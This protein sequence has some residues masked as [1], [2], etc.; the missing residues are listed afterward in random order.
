M[1]DVARKGEFFMMIGRMVWSIC[2]VPVG[3]SLATTDSPVTIFN[4]ALP[5][6]AMSGPGLEG[7]VLLFPLSPH[8]LLEL[9]HPE[10]FMGRPANF[11]RELPKEGYA[12]IR[13]CVIEGDALSPGELSVVNLLLARHADRFVVANNEPQLVELRKRMGPRID[14]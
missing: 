7:A 1:K 14:G 10:C 3:S 8:W 12:P 6:Q 13:F 2:K 9:R 5:D 4:P 11:L